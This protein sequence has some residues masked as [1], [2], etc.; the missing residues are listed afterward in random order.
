VNTLYLTNKSKRPLYLMA[1][2]VVLGGQQDRTIGNDSI[3]SA[4]TKRL[5]ITVFCVEHGR[6]TGQEAFAM[7]AK[8]VASAEIR[9]SAQN[10]AFYY[11][12]ANAAPARVQS[13]PGMMGG[14]RP[15]PPANLN[16]DT[17]IAAIGQRKVSG[18]GS[19]AAVMGNVTAGRPSDSLEPVGEAQQKVWDRV[20]AKNR[21]FKTETESG[22][23]RN[24]LNLS[25]G[26][27]GRS[28]TPYIKAFSAGL[29]ADAHLVGAVA[30]VNGKVVAADI[31]G[32]ATLF[33]KL[34]PKLLRSYAADAAEHNGAKQQTVSAVEAARFLHQAAVG[35][36][37]IQARSV[38][39]V[40]TRLVSAKAITYG[41]ASP[42]PKLAAQAASPALHENVLSK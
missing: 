19:T 24:L 17:G 25:G 42:A 31:F 32:N 22:T 28:I 8:T 18:T 13:T 41:M 4:G 2:E 9:A 39:G 23:Y 3:V 10:G 34:W 11:Q 26:E 21:H 20:A 37:R 5:P 35:R 36:D 15:G 29:P 7:S 12:V 38:T 30:A 40:N 27:A 16:A 6:W 1:G 14:G 33:R